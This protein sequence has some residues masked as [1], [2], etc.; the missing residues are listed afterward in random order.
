[1]D[2]ADVGHEVPV[3]YHDAL[4][5]LVEP[6]VYWS[7]ASVS[8]AMAGSS[9]RSARSRESRRWRATRARGR[10]RLAAVFRFHHGLKLSRARAAAQG[11]AGPGIGG[12][13]LEALEH[14]VAMR[15]VGR[16]ATQPAYRQPKKAV[17]K[18]R[19][20]G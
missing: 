7:M 9:H 16:T 18:S 20:G 17:T 12:D 11:D 3:T 1:M 8:G 19:P 5:P 15:R 13:G 4:G 10:C 14:A 2:G 6:E